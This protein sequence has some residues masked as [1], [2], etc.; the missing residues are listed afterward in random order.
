M[1]QK[2]SYTLVTCCHTSK[3][4]FAFPRDETFPLAT[5]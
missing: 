5:S 1:P 2:V 4:V 3:K